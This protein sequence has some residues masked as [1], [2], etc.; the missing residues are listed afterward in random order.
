MTLNKEKAEAYK[1]L[2]L[3]MQKKYPVYSVKAVNN[4]PNAIYKKGDPDAKKVMQE[5]A[6]TFQ[7]KQDFYDTLKEMGLEWKETNHEGIYEMRA[8]AT[9]RIAIEN[10]FDPFNFV[11]KKDT[12]VELFAPV[13]NAENIC[14]EINLYTYWQGLGYAEKTPKIKYLLVAQD[15]G[16]LN[17]DQEF[18]DKIKKYNVGDRSP[19]YSAKPPG[20]G[21][22]ENL[23]ELFE[24][25]GYDLSKRYDEL[26][27]TNFCLG[28]RSAD[29]KTVGGMTK[30]LMM[31]DAKEFKRL[32]EILEP[33]NILCLGKITAE[34]VYKTLK[35]IEL[36]DTYGN[37]KNY[38]E[39]LD[40][41]PQMVINYGT[42]DNI[43]LSNVY[44]LAHCGYMGTVN[45]PLEIQKQDWKNIA[46][47]KRIDIAIENFCNTN[48]DEDKNRV[49]DE[50]LSRVQMKGSFIIPFRNFGD[51]NFLDD[52][53]PI[54]KNLK[55]VFLNSKRDGK[56]FLA[57]FTNLFEFAK[58]NESSEKNFEFRY[59]SVEKLLRDCLKNGDNSEGIVLNPAG[60]NQFRLTRDMIKDLWNR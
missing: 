8:K 38:N 56:I 15:W 32:C 23:F 21:T 10:G 28:Y 52:V 49:L 14:H 55:S 34:C 6:A 11:T 3:D 40:N 57:A 24:V 13:V 12:P 45:R 53:I 59:V 47:E 54:F 18:I 7:N 31:K 9:L 22:D 1:K 33:E 42:K 19:L 51:G 50:I 4:D 2:V 25:L 46:D 43:I 27:F 36:E 16:N 17:L 20:I 35:N 26:F 58:F 29:A 44:P 37:A 48:T 39:F 30:E 41:Q 5:F 60:E